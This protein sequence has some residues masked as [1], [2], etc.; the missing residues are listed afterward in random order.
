MSRTQTTASKALPARRT[1]PQMP[2]AATSL[3]IQHDHRPATRRSKPTATATPQP[4]LPPEPQKSTSG[5]PGSKQADIIALL[6]RRQGA[7]LAEL[8][9]LTGWLAHS[10]RG[11]L[12]GALKRKLGLLIDS[13][14]EP[15]RGR[16][17]RIVDPAPAEPIETAAASVPAKARRSKR[18][19]AVTAAAA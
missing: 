4:V 3:L 9:H 13:R 16:V 15:N 12:S 8:M 11:V 7:S 18:H 19:A 1:E 10:V 6:R 2:V 14:I 17:Y 5:K